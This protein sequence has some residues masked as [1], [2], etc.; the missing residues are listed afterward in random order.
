M[1]EINECLQVN[2]NYNKIQKLFKRENCERNEG[3]DTIKLQSQGLSNGSVGTEPCC[4]TTCT[5]SLRPT[6]RKEKTES[7]Q[8]VLVLLIMSIRVLC[9]WSQL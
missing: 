5:R 8:I 3:I 7:P 4:L 2:N 1:L 6:Q 9:E